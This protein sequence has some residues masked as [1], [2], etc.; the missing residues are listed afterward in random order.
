MSTIPA[1]V[2]SGMFVSNPV[3]NTVK[4]SATAAIVRFATCVRPPALS[5]IWVLVGL[6]FT[7]KVPDSPAARFAPDR[8]RMSRFTS[9]RSPCLAAKL[10]EVAAL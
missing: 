8:P 2:A 1:N 7:T 9:T 6:P 4:T 10:R 3:A 5:R